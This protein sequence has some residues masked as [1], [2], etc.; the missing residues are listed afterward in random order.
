VSATGYGMVYIGLYM[1]SCEHG[2]TCR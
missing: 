2:I 1:S